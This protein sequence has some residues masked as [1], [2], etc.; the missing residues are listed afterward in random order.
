M[1]WWYLEGALEKRNTSKQQ[2]DSG[3]QENTVLEARRA[4]SERKEPE[5]CIMY[6]VELA[7]NP[8]I[9]RHISTRKVISLLNSPL[10]AKYFFPPLTFHIFELVFPDRGRDRKQEREGKIPRHW[11]FSS[12]MDA[13]VA[14]MAKHI[15]SQMSYLVSSCNGVYRMWSLLEIIGLWGGG[16]AVEFGLWRRGLWKFCSVV[17]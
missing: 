4:F 7:A 8:D 11:A 12:A 6:N 2:R 14:C 17:H 15:A 1:P 3:N 5:K 16:Y 13:G 9:S 10:S